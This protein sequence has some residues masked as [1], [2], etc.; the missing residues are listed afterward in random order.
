[1]ATL[2]LTINYLSKEEL[3]YEL[4]IKGIETGTVEE[5]RKVLGACISREKSNPDIVEDYPDYPFTDEEETEVILNKLEYVKTLVDNF[6]CTDARKVETKLWH[7]MMRARRMGEFSSARAN[8]LKEALNIQKTYQNK[9]NSLTKA[10]EVEA[11]ELLV[12]QSLNLSTHTP[13]STSSPRQG[14]LVESTTLSKGVPVH[15]WDL[16]FSGKPDAFLGAFL[17]RVDEL[18]IARGVSKEQIFQSAVGSYEKS[19]YFPLR[20]LRKLDLEYNELHTLNADTFEHIDELEELSLSHNPFKT[21]DA[22]SV[23]A[24]TSLTFLKTLNLAYAQLKTL[25]EYFL[26]APKRLNTLDLSGNLF[27]AV[28]S[29]LQ[30]STVTT[31]FSSNTL[32]RLYLERMPFLSRIAKMA[33]AESPKI[34]ELYL[35]NNRK[36]SVVEKDAFLIGNE[37]E[38][39]PITKGSYEKSLY[40]PL[41]ALRKLDLEYNELHTLNADTFEHIDE[42]EELSLSHNPFKTIDAQSVQAITSLTFLKTLNLAYAQ[43]KT[44]PEYF[45]HAP[46]RLNTLDLSGN[47]FEAV[48]S[49]LQHSTVTTLFFSKNLLK[50][51]Q[52][53]SFS[54]NTLTRLYLERMPFLSRIAKMAFAESPKISELY[55]SN[56]RKLSVVEKDAFLI[57]NE[58]QYLPI[59]KVSFLDVFD[60]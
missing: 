36:L 42:L 39:L 38:Y 40:F 35:S 30:H 41:R 27:E 59:T 6:V 32:T 13:L 50:E 52:S 15:K 11:L 49:A 1:M 23:Q 18:S 44:L 16:K 29:A 9:L 58:K 25:P 45:L 43:L 22:Q 26:H 10:A 34:S 33:F 2:R 5:M 17:E 51:L 47:L 53:P 60:H 14:P 55:L 56:N 57:G 7:L 21:I 46:K 3:N 4:L 48:P 20:A 28:P 31:F 24:I 54:S 19:L 12:N 8:C 37:K